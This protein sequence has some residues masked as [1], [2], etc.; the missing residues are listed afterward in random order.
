MSI[1]RK[2]FF[3]QGLISLGK[4]ALDISGIVKGGDATDATVISDLTTSGEPRHDMSVSPFNE[5]CLAGNGGCSDCVE[6]CQSLAIMVIP[7]VGIRI[8]E[9]RCSGCGS[10][11]YVCPVTPKAVIMQPRT[12]PTEKIA[13]NAVSTPTKL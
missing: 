13:T 3:R 2:E 11:E 6:R 8:D 4:T 1:T 10:C 9:T 5:R 12:K 7:D